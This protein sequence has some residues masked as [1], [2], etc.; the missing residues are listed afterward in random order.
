[1]DLLVK[2]LA[3]PPDVLAEYGQP[4]GPWVSTVIRNKRKDAYRAESRHRRISVKPTAS[5][6]W[7]AERPANRPSR[8]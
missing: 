2:I 3:S 5:P 8:S 1:M 4:S 7:L 6:E